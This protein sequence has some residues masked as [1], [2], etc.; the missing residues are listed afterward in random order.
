MFIRSN[1]ANN[2]PGAMAKYNIVSGLFCDITTK[3]IIHFMYRIFHTI[4]HT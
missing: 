4:R 2:Q 1:G 3:K